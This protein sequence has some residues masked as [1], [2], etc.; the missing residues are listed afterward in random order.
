[1]SRLR[2]WSAAARLAFGLAAV[3]SAAPPLT[4]IQEILYK[5]DGTRFNGIAVIQWN[6]FR[7]SDTSSIATHNVTVRIVDGILRVRLVPTTYVVNRKGMIVGMGV[8][9]VDLG[10]PEFAQDLESVRS[11]S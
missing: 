10:S 8:G 4:T 6:S 2:Q 9:P 7:A 11:A 3:L 5:A 1:M